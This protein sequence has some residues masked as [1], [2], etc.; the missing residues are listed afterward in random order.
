MDN[1]DIFIVYGCSMG[2][3]DDFYF[4]NLFEDRKD[5]LFIIYG[6]GDEKVKELMDIVHKYTGGLSNYQT[7]NSMSFI[8]CSNRHALA[9]TREVLSKWNKNID[10]Y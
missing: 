4:R 3:S 5:K 10:S 7:I 6:Y 2:P 8:D 1:S 9:E